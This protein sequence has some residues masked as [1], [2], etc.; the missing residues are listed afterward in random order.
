MFKILIVIL[1]ITLPSSALTINSEHLFIV[2]STTAANALKEINEEFYLTTGV[3]VIIRPIGSSKGVISVAEEVSDIGI[4]SR[5]LTKDEVKRWANLE[6]TTIGQDIIGIM[7]SPK[8]PIKNVSSSQLADI[9]SGQQSHWEAPEL[10]NNN[11]SLLSKENS[12]G[13]FDSFISFLNL[14]SIKKQDKLFFKHKGVAS[15]YKGE[16]AITYDNI[17][18]AI[19]DLARSDNAIAYDSITSYKH[20]QKKQPNI[21]IKLLSLNGI[22]PIVKNTVNKNYPLKRPINL[23]SQS[24]SRPLVKDY[25]KLIMSKRGQAILEESYVIPIK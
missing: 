10:T 13:T 8:N 5:Y 12:H 2:G 11:I 24:N 7:V 17:F 23:V 6:Q 3:Q 4:V 15:I 14:Q 18:Q 20:F 16:G 21:Q 19:G 9:Y 1:L 25:I 22:H